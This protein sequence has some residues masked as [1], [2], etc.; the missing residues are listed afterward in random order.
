MIFKR[1]VDKELKENF[2]YIDK[3]GFVRDFRKTKN[4]YKKY[5]W[6]QSK[7]AF[8]VGVIVAI[9]LIIGAGSDMYNGSTDF[10]D[11]ILGL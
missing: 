3:M 4:G 6:T 7:L 10:V 11:R 2:S 8:V 5:F 1:T 9:A